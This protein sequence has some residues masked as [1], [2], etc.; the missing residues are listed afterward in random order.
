MAET[1]SDGITTTVFVRLQGDLQK[2]RQTV[3]DITRPWVNGVALRKRGIRTDP[4]TIRGITNAGSEGQADAA[5]NVLAGY[6]GKICTVTMNGITYVNLACVDARTMQ[7]RK[8]A[9]VAGGIVTNGL[10]IIEAE[11]DFVYGGV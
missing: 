9:N 10:W 2:P 4:Y 8:V 7:P 1:I 11:L 6:A 3:E 5:L